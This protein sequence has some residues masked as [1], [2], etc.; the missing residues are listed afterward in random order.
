[1]D[2]AYD[3][4]DIDDG[5]RAELFTLDDIAVVAL[6][7]RI[8]ADIRAAFPALDLSRIVHEFI[9]RLI[10][11]LIEDLVAETRRNLAALA[12]RSVDDVRNA[13]SG[14]AGFSP[15][16]AAAERSIKGFLETRM[17]R[18]ARVQRVMSEAAGVV[19]DLFR[20]Y[21]KHSGDLP[22]E[23]REGLAD[24]DDTARAR[25]IADFIAGMTDRFALAEH[26]R[27][28]DSTPELR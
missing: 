9:R 26:A 16:I 23:W 3:A 10:G 14:I 6:P 24:A 22:A 20:H 18:H 5:L 25:R 19:R 21:T 15:A 4:H 1:D 2:I 13:S 11:L 28:F 12:P 17:Y 7:G 8:L 27:L